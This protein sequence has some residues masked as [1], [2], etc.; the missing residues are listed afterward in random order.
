MCGGSSFEMGKFDIDVCLG[1]HGGG[2]R[3]DSPD[4]EYGL[5]SFGAGKDDSEELRSFLSEFSKEDLVNGI[6]NMLQNGEEY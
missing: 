5:F 1:Y 2:F 3:Y 6:V 4:A